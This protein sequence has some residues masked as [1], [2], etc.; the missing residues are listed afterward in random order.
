MVSSSRRLAAGLLVLALL[1]PAG[2]AIAFDPGQPVIASRNTAG[3]PGGDPCLFVQFARNNPRWLSMTCLF[4]LV[5]DDGNGRYDSYLLDRL[6]GLIERVSVS[7][8]GQQVFYPSEGG[9]PSD[10]GREVVFL[11]GGPLHPDVDTHGSGA[12]EFG[13]FNVFVRDR[14]AGTTEVIS[15]DSQGLPRPR[16]GFIPRDAHMANGEVLLQTSQW[17]LL[18]IGPPISPPPPPQIYAR[19]WRTGAVELISVGSDGEPG[20]YG[21]TISS[22]DASGRYVTFISGSTN[23]PG[24]NPAP[25][26]N[27]FVRDRVA[28]TTTRLTRPWHGGEFAPGR[29]PVAGQTTPRLSS[30]QRYVLFTST[31]PELIEEPEPPDWMQVY[32]LE[33]QED[34]LER[35]SV[36]ADGVAADGYS[37]KADLSDDGRYLAFYSQAT[38]LPAGGRAIYVVDRDSGEW[39]TVT[40]GLGGHLGAPPELDLASDGSAIA[41]VW[42][43]DDTSQPGIY[44]RALVYTVELGT[45]APRPPAQPVPNGSLPSWWL[46][47]AGLLLMASRRLR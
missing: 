15:R 28:G 26:E 30:D 19:N 36:T 34:R 31:N 27:L 25:T 45:G 16:G 47:I 32:L 2:A 46:L 37:G 12:P 9:F 21:A 42:R 1:A 20:N 40:T 11:S 23:L 5:P 29:L 14:V 7:S 6:S 33:R 22:F 10:N 35:I 44:N 24:A 39:L 38:N 18:P 13:Y 4:A 43:S 8:T 17:L 41:F 3:E